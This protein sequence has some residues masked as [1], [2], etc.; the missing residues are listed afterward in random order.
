MGDIFAGTF[1]GIF[2]AALLKYLY[3]KEIW[4]DQFITASNPIEELML[5]VVLIFFLTSVIAAASRR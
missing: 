4:V 2:L 1:F 3:D 5:I